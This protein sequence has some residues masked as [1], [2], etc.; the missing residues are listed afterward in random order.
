MRGKYFLR[1]RKRKNK[2]LKGGMET[3]KYQYYLNQYIKLD[4]CTVI[5]L[6]IIVRD[7]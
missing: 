6:C 5:D 4:T 2:K 7:Q 3:V 1:D